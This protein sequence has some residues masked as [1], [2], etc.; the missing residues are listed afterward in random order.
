MTPVN[1]V[2]PRS[3]DPWQQVPED[4]GLMGPIGQ[5]DDLEYLPDR[6]QTPADPWESLEG[7]DEA[8]EPAPRSDRQ[9]PEIPSENKVF[10]QPTPPSRLPRQN[11]TLEEAAQPGTPSTD[12]PPITPD[13]TAPSSEI[14]PAPAP[15][16]STSES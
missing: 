7:D 6:W 15:A 11:Q 9:T 13:A 12:P 14:T 4:T 5:P 16:L 1:P 2:R 3:R 8:F 10:P